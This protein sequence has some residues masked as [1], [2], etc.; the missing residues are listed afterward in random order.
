MSLQKYC[1]AARHQQRSVEC[2]GQTS[3][4]KPGRHNCIDVSIMSH[5]RRRRKYGG[6]VTRVVTVCIEHLLLTTVHMH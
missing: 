1:S 4:G 6:K 2:R 3:S 5:C